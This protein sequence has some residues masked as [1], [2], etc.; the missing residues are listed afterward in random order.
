MVFFS[1]TELE[2]PLWTMAKHQF[3]LP[4]EWRVPS[5]I[6]T[7]QKEFLVAL[8]IFELALGDETTYILGDTFSGADI[9]LA[10][11]LGWANKAGVLPLDSSVRSYME[12]CIAR[13]A[14]ARAREREI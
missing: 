2:Q 1:M 3:A 11:T 6:D 10:L 14:L 12:R 4:E 13:P 5:I 8:K 7:A 9:L